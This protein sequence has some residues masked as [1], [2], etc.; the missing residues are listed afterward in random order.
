MCCVEDPG[1][2]KCGTS[3][4]SSQY[5]GGTSAA[6]EQN[7]RIL[8]AV[9]VLYLCSTG[10][11]L[12]QCQSRSSAVPGH[13][14][15]KSVAPLPRAPRA[16]S[17]GLG[18][19]V[20]PKV[21]AWLAPDRGQSRLDFDRTSKGGRGWSRG[22][23]PRPIWPCQPLFP[24]CFDQCWRDFGQMRAF[25]TNCGASS[26]NIRQHRQIR[27]RL[28]PNSCDIAKFAASSNGLG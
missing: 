6:P 19:P 20:G 16:T 1:S 22:G 13:V 24:A 12:A 4:V 3:P 5:Q 26:A 21:Q 15:S 7:Q 9:P 18:P 11:V 28:N 2:Y 14:G 23:C 10:A 27:A 8:G 25:S 17:G